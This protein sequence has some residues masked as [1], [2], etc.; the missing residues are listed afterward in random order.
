MSTFELQVYQGSGWQFDA[1]FDSRDMVISEAQRMDSA[2][3][4]MGV[5]VLE[6]FFNE[7]S[8][9]TS[10]RTIFSRLRKNETIGA[11]QKAATKSSAPRDTARRS[12]PKSKRK[13]S[14]GNVTL[15]LF[16]GIAMVVIGIA[17]IILLREYAGAY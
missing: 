7:E 9:V 1:Y 5:R 10:Y 16:A 4:Y 2:G 13:K 14:G 17:A 3:R 6:E 8:Q 12:R 11:P 15:L